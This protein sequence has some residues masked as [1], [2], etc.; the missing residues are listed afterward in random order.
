MAHLKLVPPPEAC[1]SLGLLLI[2][3]YPVQFTSRILVA[4]SRVRAAT[5]LYMLTVASVKNT[6]PIALQR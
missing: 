4:L 3:Q 1:L 6:K 2:V 5:L